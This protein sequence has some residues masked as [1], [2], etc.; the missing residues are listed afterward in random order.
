MSF[1]TGFQ[2][3]YKDGSTAY[4]KALTVAIDNFFADSNVLNVAFTHNNNR[5]RFV[6][7]GGRVVVQKWGG[8]EFVE[9]SV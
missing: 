8:R 4:H 1:Q 2:L 9:V 6:K 5:Y 3:S 7:S